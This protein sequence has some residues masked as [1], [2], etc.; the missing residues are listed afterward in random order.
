MRSVSE[1]E[2][3]AQQRCW[4]NGL[5]AFAGRFPLHEHVGYAAL[6]GLRKR[7]GRELLVDVTRGRLGLSG[8]LL[9]ALG[10]VL[11]KR[12]RK[13]VRQKRVGIVLPPGAGA[14]L[15]NLACF[16]CG[17]TPVNINFT[18]DAATIA[19]C[20]RRS[21]VETVITAKAFR[22]RLP[23][24]PWPPRCI[25]IMD[26]MK[27]LPKWKVA[28]W[29]LLGRIVPSP[30]LA[31]LAGVPREGGTREAALLFTSGS[32][33]APKGV[34]L[35]HR[36]LLGN[37]CQISLYNVLH[38]GD[39]LMATLP[40]FHSFGFTVGLCFPLVRGLRMVTLPSPLET[41]HIAEAIERERVTVHLATPT[42]LRPY[43]R[44]VKP[45][46]LASLRAVVA[47]A[48]KTPAG[49]HERWEQ[50]FGSRY[51]EGYGLTETTPVVAC[52]IPDTQGTR[53]GSVGKLFQGMAA[54]IR[55]PDTLVAQSLG[56]V[57]LL[58]LRGVNVFEGY[59][60]DEEATRACFHE[61]WFMTGDLAR[62]DADGFLY[63]EGR[64]SRFSKIAGEMVPHALV[65]QKLLQAL[66]KD[67][68]SSEG[69]ELA[70]TA[71]A[72]AVKGE[73]LVVV[74]TQDLDVVELRM[75]V[76]RA[77][78]ELPNLWMPREVRR[79]ERIPL[80]GSGKLDLRA[81]RKLAEKAP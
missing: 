13:E 31:G 27:R 38:E 22:E 60:D 48:E 56:Q 18:L 33:N 9:L 58:G 6:K 21:G 70:V 76:Q 64:L 54:C 11:A 8:Y 79:V 30:W 67:E 50:C 71:R 78:I 16:L 5:E 3:D 14:A 23:N 36:N 74:S 59:L 57:G 19:D 40:V 34:V 41:G 72:D 80:L 15:A 45:E 65:E 44:K 25:D 62:M 81:L 10:L 61:G 73:A 17:K 39:T 68:S 51:L 20:M 52:N 12:L 4:D 1:T 35:T 24:F 7:G 28:V 69:P 26:T 43:L 55:N 47:G 53:V 75:K 32:T 37:I 49:F 77:G 42:L 46:K 29:A 63:I 2:P 66:G